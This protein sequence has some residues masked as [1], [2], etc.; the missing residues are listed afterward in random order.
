MPA[1][2]VL[3][4]SRLEIEITEALALFRDDELRS[5]AAHLRAIRV[6]Y[7]LDDFGTGYSSLSYP[8]SGFHS[9]SK[10]EPMLCH[11]LGGAQVHRPIVHPSS[12]SQSAKH[13]DRL[14][15]G[16]RDRSTREMLLILGCTEMQ[17]YLFRPHG[18]CGIRCCFPENRSEI[19]AAEPRRSSHG[20]SALAN[21]P[22]VLPGLSQRTHFGLW[23]A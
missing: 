18:V 23:S 5:L 21:T 7:P 6:A 4:A 2:S 19:A 13:D 12:T 20:D 15:R 14:Q 8:C 11:D 10:I 16:R 3:S 22:C 1:T 9:K 17:G